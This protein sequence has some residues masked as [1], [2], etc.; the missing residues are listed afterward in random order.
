MK[1]DRKR[2]KRHIALAI[3]PKNA[4]V[5]LFVI[6]MAEGVRQR[7]VADY[8]AHHKWFCE[9]IERFQPDVKV[10]VDV[11]PQILREY[12]YH[13]TY[14]MPHFEGHPLK[15]DVEKAKRGLKPASVNLR[16]STM[17]AFCRW[18]NG[19]GNTSDESIR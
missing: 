6:V 9:W 17:K 14:E 1:H 4:H 5:T 18:L 13:L 15:S 2:K 12:I 8:R 11:T 10:V 16:I 3:K 7:T 19:E